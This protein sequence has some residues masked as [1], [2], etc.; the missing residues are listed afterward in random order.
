MVLIIYNY[1]FIN[2]LQNQIKLGDEVRD[3]Q[4]LMRKLAPLQNINDHYPKFL[5]TLDE[6]PAVDYDGI[7]RI[8]ALNWLLD[9]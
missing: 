6:D 4:T 9:G 5:L 3:N 1:R 7:R 8:N 2:I